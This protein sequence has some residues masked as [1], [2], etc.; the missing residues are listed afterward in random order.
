MATA[1]YSGTPLIKKLGIKEGFR[2]SLYQAPDKYFDWLGADI[3]GQ[4]CRGSEIPDLVHLFAFRLQ[5]FEKE[6]RSLSTV[7]RKNPRLVIWVSW[8]KK[9]SGKATDLT[10][11]AIRGYALQHGLVDIKV[12]AVSDE[13]SGLKL[14]VPLSKR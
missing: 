10:E 4:L 7:W 1:G 8:Y 11:D 13:W 6:M 5:D 9:S 2:I 3:S 12:C 14:V